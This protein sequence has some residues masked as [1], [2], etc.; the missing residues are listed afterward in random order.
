MGSG[1]A[2]KRKE[3]GTMPMQAKNQL[4]KGILFITC[5]FTLG[6]SGISYAYWTNGLGVSGNISTDGLDV[7]FSGQEAANLVTNESGN[8]NLQ[9]TYD[10]E[11]TTLSIEGTVDP[12]YLGSVEYTIVNQ[13]QLPV[14][15]SPDT[16]SSGGIDN[17]LS[18]EGEQVTALGD[19]TYLLKQNGT[20]TGKL[21]VEV[22]EEN[23]QFEIR[24]PY[25][26][27][28]KN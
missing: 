4:G 22:G 11:R 13:G 1:I 3:K 17:T 9:V 6:L 23:V 2:G 19:G 24:I 5:I 10:P 12:G 15:F 21:A 25:E 18:F 14:R 26:Q 7:V 28:V 20:G 16:P 27:W 8:G